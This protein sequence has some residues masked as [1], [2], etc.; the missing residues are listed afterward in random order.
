MFRS[1]KIFNRVQFVYIKKLYIKNGRIRGKSI[2][3]KDDPGGAKHWFNLQTSFSFSQ[4][5]SKNRK[6][7]SGRNGLCGGKVALL[8]GTEATYVTHLKASDVI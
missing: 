4:L 1:R 8:S 3:K 6:K 7:G 5:N 2:K